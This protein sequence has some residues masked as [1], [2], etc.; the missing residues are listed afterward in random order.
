ML[1][2]LEMLVLSTSS[3]LRFKMITLGV[4]VAALLAGVTVISISHIKS[5]AQSIE[6]GNEVTGPLYVAALKG[7]EKVRLI[8]DVS[9]QV[10]RDCIQHRHEHD[11]AEKDILKFQAVDLLDLDALA[12]YAAGTDLRVLSDSILSAGTRLSAFRKLMID[13]CHDYTD[14]YADFIALKQDISADIASLQAQLDRLISAAD[15][16][17]SLDEELAKVALQ[18]KGRSGQDAS[19]VLDHAMM[20]SWPL[21]RSL[22]GMREL[23]VRLNNSLEKE[24]EVASNSSVA[25]NS[26]LDSHYIR[27]LQMG[28]RRL[29]PRLVAE[30]DL[31]TVTTMEDTIARIS[32][33]IDGKDG[34]HRSRQ[35]SLELEAALSESAD[36]LQKAA[37]LLEAN[38]LALSYRA[39]QL[40]TEAAETMRARIGRAAVTIGSV[41]VAAALICF[42]A[43]MFFG[44]GLTRPIEMLTKHTQDIESTTCMDRPLPSGL[45]ERTD[46][47]GSL[48][49]SFD[50]LMH[51][52]NHARQQLVAESRAEV[53]QQY[54]R[55]KAAL[56]SIPQGVCLSDRN[57]KVLMVNGQY[58]EI[59]GLRED[60]VEL[61]MPVTE[62][63]AACAKQGAWLNFEDGEDRKQ[64]IYARN[65]FISKQRIVSFPDGRTVVITTAPTPDG[66][67]ISISEDITER[68]RQEA[69][70]VHL[71]HHDALTGLPNR[72]FFRKEVSK[73]LKSLG[74][75]QSHALLYLDLDEFKAVN[76]TLGHPIGDQLLINV[77]K[78]LRAGIAEHDHV[79]RLGGDEFAIMLRDTTRWEDVAGIAERLIQTIA[80]PYNVAGHFIVVGVSIGIALAPS[81]GNDADTLM[82]NADMALYRAKQEGR[83]RHRFFEPEMNE[84]MQKRRQL[85]LEMRA[86]LNDEG[87]QV[88]YQPLLNFAQNRVEAFEALLRWE[89]PDRGNIP[90]ADFIPLAEETGL[91]EQIGAWVLN[92]ACMDARSWP[93][94]IRIAINIS[95]LQFR[96]GTLAK[97]VMT[98]IAASELRPSRLELEITEGV[99]LRD[100]EATLSILDDLRRVG[101]RIVMDDFGTGYSSLSY[102]TKFGFDK[103]KIDQTFVHA[104]PQSPENLAVVKS[105]ASLCRSLNIATVAEGVE[106]EEQFRLLEEAGCTEAQGYLIGRPMPAKKAL[107]M[108][109]K[110]RKAGSGKL[111]SAS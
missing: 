70:I 50:S 4:L 91:I 65:F 56:D 2:S 27:L 24:L 26:K 93:D 101:I 99:L 5:V 82:K 73:A 39:Q 109:E 61:G 11:E 31:Q 94:D 34:L 111:R 15:A 107:A 62:L 66:G 9:Q 20:Q 96:T 77:A 46:E 6:L 87:F 41:S 3:R 59:F 60:Q 35:L 83:N 79:A 71:A 28:F 81:D 14:Q 63:I 110:Q 78:R 38:V 76:D 19:E 1:R 33:G 40:N 12:L 108:I 21:L 92:R 54:E 8:S 36:D 43:L 58:R 95:P 37:S 32:T 45:L 69:K 30:G 18:T 67:E 48:A 44:A 52:L 55:L 88:H 22:Y 53:R 10:I 13:R 106:T 16:A 103:I 85:E 75:G 102:L 98:A 97:D 29:K 68:K 7:T 23:T 49:R 90:P 80:Q 51:V 72:V 47:I 57:R 84:R 64:N 100:T 86:A 89:H 104:I 42:G 17:M 105:V 25:A 74:D